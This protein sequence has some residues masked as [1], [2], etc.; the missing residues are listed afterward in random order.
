MGTIWKNYSV[1]VCVRVFLYFCRF[2]FKLSGPVLGMLLRIIFA[3]I[4]NGFLEDSVEV[5]LPDFYLSFQDLIKILEDRFPDHFNQYPSYQIELQY[6]S[7]TRLLTTADA[8]SSEFPI[9]EIFR[10]YVFQ[11]PENFPMPDNSRYTFE[12]P[13]IN[14]AD[15][16][17]NII[18]PER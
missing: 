15:S 8:L 4:G 5:S 3:D 2:Q 11:K 6:N 14:S 16:S 10:I 12:Y 17:A 9:V 18:D 13:A 1:P 7:Q